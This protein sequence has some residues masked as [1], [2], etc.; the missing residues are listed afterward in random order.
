MHTLPHPTDRSEPPLETAVSAEPPVALSPRLLPPDHVVVD[1]AASTPQALYAAIGEVVA[2][3]GGPTVRQVVQRLSGRHARQSP[4]LGEG[5]ALPHAAVPALA[6]PCAV[7]VRLDQPLHLGAPDG[8]PV[9]DCLAVLAP[10]PGF[11]ADLELLDQ[12]RR[13]ITSRAVVEGL[14]ASEGVAQIQALLCG[15][16]LA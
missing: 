8:R 14:R 11:A 12:A 3:R 1:V 10:M 6:R 4:A 16:P 2:R 13:W 15:L 7:F 5:V 9:R